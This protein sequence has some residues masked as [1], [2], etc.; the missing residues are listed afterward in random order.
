MFQAMIALGLLKANGKQ[1]V[2]D[3][4]LMMLLLCIGTH[5]SIKFIIFSLVQDLPVRSM[6]NTFIGFCYSPLIFLYVKKQ[7]DQSFSPLSKWYLF[8]PFL[9]AMVGYLT[10]VS[11]LNISLS[12]GHQVLGVYNSITRYAMPLFN[13][14]LAVPAFLTI[15]KFP[16]DQA[17]EA[18]LSRR[19]IVCL[20]SVSL[21]GIVFN[22]FAFAQDPAGQIVIRSVCYFLLGLI[23]ILVLRSKFNLSS[24]VDEV[25]VIGIQQESISKENQ[26]EII[27][28]V[29]L[30]P[31]SESDIEPEISIAVET[32]RPEL[33][34]VE[35]QIVELSHSTEASSS[36]M[37][38]RSQLSR[39]EHEKIYRK[40]ETYLARSRAYSDS[41]LS[42]DKLASAIGVSRYSV[43][44][45]LN[46]YAGKSFYQ[47]INEWRIRQVTEQIEDLARKDIPI[48]F[49]ILAY[50]N[51]FKAKSSFN[52]YFKKITG[53]TPTAY[54]KGV[55]G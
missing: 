50:D 30:N 33:D 47:Y 2:A 23:C 19:I 14:A 52:T 6:M 9:F 36:A 8:I 44:E 24:K 15:R 1:N 38:R 16:P 40:L 26:K 34:K 4:L 29:E 32:V 43:S 28:F 27:P 3:R 31:S 5:L 49:L 17:P 11:V 25:P 35:L 13:L 22:S 37:F 39:D 54:L 51:G 20:M 41:E 18:R 45:T 21:F 55:V 46:H 42:M 53:C 48:N 12:I 7:A 10:V